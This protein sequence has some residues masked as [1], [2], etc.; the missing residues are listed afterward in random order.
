VAGFLPSVCN[1]ALALENVVAAGAQFGD[2][3][4]GPNLWLNPDTLQ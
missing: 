3:R 4:R 2:G 1:P